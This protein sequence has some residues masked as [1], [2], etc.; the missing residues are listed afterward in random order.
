VAVA[1]G[2]NAALS[3]VT[4][5]R[6]TRTSRLAN[7]LAVVGRDERASDPPDQ[8]EECGIGRLVHRAELPARFRHHDV[9]AAERREQVDGVRAACGL[10]LSDLE[11]GVDD[12]RLRMILV[13]NP[14][15]LFWG[16]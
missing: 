11:W 7:T 15:K 4:P 12:A 2:V 9:A 8:R 6:P 10:E 5:R 16:G 1:T 14:R 3:S 13:D